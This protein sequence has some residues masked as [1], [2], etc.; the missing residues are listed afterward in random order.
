MR[1][2]MDGGLVNPFATQ[3]KFSLKYNVSPFEAMHTVTPL[4][5][6]ADGGGDSYDGGG[7][8]ADGGGDSYDGG[9]VGDLDGPEAISYIPHTTRPARATPAVNPS[10]R[11]SSL[12]RRSQPLG[13]VSQEVYL[14]V[15]ASR[16]GPLIAAGWII[17]QP[18]RPMLRISN[19]LVNL[20]L[21]IYFSMWRSSGSLSSRSIGSRSSRPWTLKDTLITHYHECS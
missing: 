4:S 7:D 19:A 11:R 3:S 14:P 2:S 18:L 1:S 6:G 15:A 8:G 21:L 5:D 16:Q 20:F 17:A 10:A 13:P 12:D 9:G